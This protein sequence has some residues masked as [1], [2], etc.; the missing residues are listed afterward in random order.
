[1][2]SPMSITA[3][4]LPWQ[5]GDYVESHRCGQRFLAGQMLCQ[6]LRLAQLYSLERRAFSSQH[7]NVV[8]SGRNYAACSVPVSSI[9]PVEERF[10]CWVCTFVYD[11]HAI[12]KVFSSGM[13]SICLQA[14]QFQLEC[15]LKAAVGAFCCTA[16]VT[17]FLDSPP[18]ESSCTLCQKQ[19]GMQTDHQ[20]L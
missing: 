9:A 16:I 18:C 20:L 2:S 13:C 3:A 19:Q 12:L 6:H 10:S 1:M 8:F 15:L 4:W 17:D 11:P 7:P 14:S 5:A